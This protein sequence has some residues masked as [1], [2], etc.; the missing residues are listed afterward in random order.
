MSTR[1]R[2]R[3]RTRTSVRMASTTQTCTQTH[4]STHAAVE[5]VEVEKAGTG[6][7]EWEASRAVLEYMLLVGC[8]TPCEKCNVVRRG[9]RLYGS[10]VTGVIYKL[11]KKSRPLYCRFLPAV[12]WSCEIG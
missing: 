7:M 8:V 6:R 5:E 3:T 11:Q 2:T 1:T 4:T 12:G 10:A 9:I